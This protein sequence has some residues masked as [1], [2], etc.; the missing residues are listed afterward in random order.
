MG[1]D[2]IQ[3]MPLRTKRNGGEFSNT[4]IDYGGPMHLEPSLKLSLPL[5]LDTVCGDV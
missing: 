4:D 5:A 3:P 1:K 2:R